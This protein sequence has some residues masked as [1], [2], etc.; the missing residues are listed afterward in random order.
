MRRVTLFWLNL[1]IMDVVLFFHNEPDSII[2]S[3]YSPSLH[4]S[5]H[6]I[7]DVMPCRHVVRNQS[8][9]RVTEKEKDK[10]QQSSSPTKE[11]LS[12]EHE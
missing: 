2:L 3:A 10:E 6:Y 5:P 11:R 4:R 8:V 12:I 9:L 7:R 1:L